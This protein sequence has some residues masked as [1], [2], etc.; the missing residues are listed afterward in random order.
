MQGRKLGK[1]IQYVLVLQAYILVLL[2]FFLCFFFF[3]EFARR[4]PALFLNGTTHDSISSFHAFHVLSQ[5]VVIFEVPRS[6][7]LGQF[8]VF[9][10]NN[11]LYS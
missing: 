5:I 10:E 9:K 1:T 6:G 11:D 7:G 3:N 8:Q 2:F 4:D